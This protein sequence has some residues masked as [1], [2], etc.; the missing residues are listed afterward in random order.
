MGRSTPTDKPAVSY[1]SLIAD[2]SLRLQQIVNGWRGAERGEPLTALHNTCVNAVGPGG[3]HLV[4]ANLLLVPDLDVTNLQIALRNP[5]GR[6]QGAGLRFR[7]RPTGRFDAALIPARSAGNV[8]DRWLLAIEEKLSLR[9]QV[10]LYAHALG[11]LLLNR[12]QEKMA[13]W[14]TSLEF[15]LCP[16]P[17]KGVCRD[18]HQVMVTCRYGRDC[19]QNKIEHDEPM[20]LIKAL[21]CRS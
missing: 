12:E 2:T 18:L 7:V 10:A 3:R 5:N 14:V 6:G 17:L 13:S 16:T 11:H 9:D 4:P 15:P 8:P 20:L 19:H 1:P 21:S